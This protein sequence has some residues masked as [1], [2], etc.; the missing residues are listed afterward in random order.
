ML[1]YALSRVLLLIPIALGV[2]LIVFLT[3]RLI[4]GDLVRIMLGEVGSP[5]AV[6]ALRAQLGLDQPWYT[7]LIRWLGNLIRGDLGTSLRTGQPVLGEVLDRIPATVQLTAFATLLV[8]LIGI[9]L[10]VLA[11]INRNTFVD[12]AVRVVGFLGLTVPSFWL[13]L[14]LVLAFALTVRWF[15]SGGYVGLFE[16]P[17]QALKHTLLPAVSLALPSAAV[18]MRYTRSSMLEVLGLDYVRTARSKGISEPRVVYVHALR[19]AV[20]NVITVIG[21]QVGFMLGGSIAVETIFRWPGMGQLTFHAIGNR[22][23]TIAQG[24]ALFIA[25]FF[26][27][28]TI[29]VD[30]LYSFIDPRIRYD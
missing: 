19:N 27:F 22:D 16:D 20:L 17:W 9:P 13:A 4:P 15:P 26:S 7:Q 12:F 14:L 30:I 24:A 21:L 25:L 3:L 11:A 28:V 2:A 10:G 1:K 8:A 23:Y 6:A 29:V 5:E 18:V